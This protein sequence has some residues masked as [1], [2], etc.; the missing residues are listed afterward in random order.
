[1]VKEKRYKNARVHL[2]SFFVL[3]MRYDDMMGKVDSFFFNDWRKPFLDL[4]GGM[5]LQKCS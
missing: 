4:G 2:L 3:G 1:M 5:F